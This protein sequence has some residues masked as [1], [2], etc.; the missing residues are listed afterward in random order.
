[1][2]LR[3]KL[4]ERKEH[5]NDEEEDEE[6]EEEPA[7][8]VKVA[9]AAEILKDIETEDNEWLEMKRDEEQIEEQLKEA[10]E[11]QGTEQ[12]KLGG[13]MDLPTITSTEKTEQNDDEEGE[14]ETEIEKELKE[15]IQCKFWEN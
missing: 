10:L 6:I 13:V 14:E 9:T 3:D 7:K 11:T 5:D 8:K 4:K 2:Q 12:H 1:M 15:A